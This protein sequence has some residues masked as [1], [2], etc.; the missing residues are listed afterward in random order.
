[1]NNSPN[2]S[3]TAPTFRQCGGGGE[4]WAQKT[5][6]DKTYTNYG[7][8][9]TQIMDTHQPTG[10]YPHKTQI[11]D[12]RT[13]VGTHT[14]HGHA[15]TNYG[16][17]TH[18]ID[19]HTSRHPTHKSMDEKQNKPTASVL[20]HVYIYIYSTKIPSLWPNRILHQSGYSIYYPFQ[21]VYHT[22]EVRTS[23]VYPIKIRTAI[24]LMAGISLDE[25]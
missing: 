5:N 22:L 21:L 8:S 1:M 15:C 18:I 14:N 20:A 6:Y 19:T 11:M 13:T 12:I 4:V 24:A 17:G 3:H 16:H 23:F 9:H 10:T 7:Q 2:H 25:E